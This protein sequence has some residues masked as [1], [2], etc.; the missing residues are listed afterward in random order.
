[1]KCFYRLMHE[2]SYLLTTFTSNPEVL[3]AEPAFRRSVHIGDG[4]KIPGDMPRVTA[5]KFT[6]DMAFGE[7]DDNKVIYNA[8]TKP[9]IDL[10]F[11]VSNNNQSTF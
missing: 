5:N 4:G 10:A 1:M 6:V 8:T 7:D 3:C 11:Q 2:D 9:L